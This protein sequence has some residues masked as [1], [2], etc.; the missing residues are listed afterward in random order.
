MKERKVDFDSLQWQTSLQ[1]AR[2]KAFQHGARTL[3]LV[4]FTKDFV[5]P[6]WCRKG[7]IGYVLAGEMDIS[8]GGTAVRFAAGDGLFIAAGEE[9]RHK[10]TV[11]TDVVRLIL[12]EDT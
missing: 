10:A 7:H 4:E 8:F 1:G 12:V 6:E 9:N 2:Y 5:E 11:I 3:R